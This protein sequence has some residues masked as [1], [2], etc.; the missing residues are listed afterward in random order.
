MD[1]SRPQVYRLENRKLVYGGRG[2]FDM[3]FAMLVLLLLVIG[4]VMVLSAS[5]P[6]AFYE[7]YKA[8]KNVG[9][10]QSTYYFNRQLI[11]AV[12]GLLMMYVVS[13][14]PMEF[15]R[16]YSR[17][18]MLGSIL[19][20]AAVLLVGEVRNGARRWINLGFTDFQPSEFTK[21]AIILYFSAMIA[22]LKD[23]IRRFCKGFLPLVVVLL[24]NAGLLVKEP[25]LSATIII[26]SVG[27]LLMFIGGTR[28]RWIVFLLILLV[29]VG[30]IYIKS[31]EGYAGNR[32]KIWANPFD[33]KWKTNEGYQTVQSLISVGSGG[34]FGL[35]LGQSRQKYLYLPEEHNDFIFA[36]ICEELGF[37]GAILILALFALLIL[38]GF[39]LAF[40]CQNRFHFL[41]CVGI[42]IQISLQVFFN[43]AVCT[44]LI[45][46]TGIS[47]PFFSYG[48]TALVIQLMEMGLVL[49]ISRDIPTR[50]I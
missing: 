49:S 45:P 7:A 32:I 42:M 3:P 26:F 8:K 33:E 23:K 37:V 48:G 20:L 41:V 6:S 39:W 31:K 9:I 30:L 36:I 38:R 2:Q 44:N 50:K 22:K 24:I 35:G 21:I 15:F 13:R 34:F 43:V 1:Y 17:L 18:L 46:C 10:S 40:H 5:F 29:V 47:L 28:K 14:I 4:V 27:L 16:K 25:H 11:F 19:L 12:L